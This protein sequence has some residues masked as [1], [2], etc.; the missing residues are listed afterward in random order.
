MKLNLQLPS[1]HASAALM[2]SYPNSEYINILEGVTFLYTSNPVLI[3]KF[4]DLRKELYDKDPKFVG[5]RNFQDEDISS[6]IGDNHIT[7][8]L[9]KGDNCIGGGVLTLGGPGQTHLLPLEID[10]NIDEPDQPY[11]L[12]KMLPEL[13]L[14]KFQ[15]VEASRMLIHPDY[16][17]DLRYISTMFVNL[18][19]RARDEKVHY[20]FAM[21]DKRRCRM[22]RKI[23]SVHIGTHANLLTHI[24]LPDRTDFE[25]VKMQI[26]V[27]DIQNTYVKALVDRYGKPTLL[28]SG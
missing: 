1:N 8:L 12:R 21:T 17:A 15:Y 5:F 9:M 6:Y 23:T 3:G 19:H 16:R 2:Q 14:E 20:L 26:I 22:Y 24:T 7:Q 18:Y 28:L 25:G 10:L 13:E 27:G 11:L 4:I